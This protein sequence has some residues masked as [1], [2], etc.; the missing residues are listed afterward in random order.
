MP[1]ESTIPVRVVQEEIASVEHQI[2]LFVRALVG[3]GAEN[4]AGQF[5]FAVPQ[6]FDVI[7]ITDRPAVKG[8]LGVIVEPEITDYADLMS[9]RP[10]WAPNKP[11]GTFRN[12]DLWPLID[13]V[14]ARRD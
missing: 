8:Q 6:Q 11:G 2:G 4:E 14:R 9:D 10:A 7:E 12:E 13:R 1:R 5:V 3:V